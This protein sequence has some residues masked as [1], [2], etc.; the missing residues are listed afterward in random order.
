[1][2]L[3]RTRATAVFFPIAAMLAGALV[4][5]A[6]PNAAHATEEFATQTGKT[7]TQCHKSAKGGK[8]NTFG[9]KFKARG[10]KLPTAAK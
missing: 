10:D 1:M 9:K 5:L 2:A 4:F 6:L 3:Q 8:L 7:C